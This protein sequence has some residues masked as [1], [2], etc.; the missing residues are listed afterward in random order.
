[1]HPNRNLTRIKKPGF[2]L[3]ALLLLRCLLPLSQAFAQTDEGLHYPLENKYNFPFSTS[4]V[5]SPMLMPPPSNVTQTVVYDPSTN[6]YVFSEKVGTL[7]YRPPSLMSFNQYQNYQRNQAKTDYWRTKSREESGAGPD[8]MKGFRLGNQSI[9]KVFGS[10]A[11]SITPQGSA[12]LIFGYAI[13]TNRN[14][15]IPVNNQRN[16]SFIFKEK[17]MMNVTGAIGD[18]LQVGLNYNTEASFDFENK[19]KLEYSGK[20]DEIIKKIQAGDVSFPVP[21]TLITG[22]QSLFGIYTELQ[23]GRLTVSTILSNQKSQQSSVKVQGGAQQTEFEVDIDN[24]DANRHFF[25]S[26]FFRDNYNAWLKNPQNIES[27][28]RIENI[29]VWVVNRQGNF[30][31]SRN[32]VGIMD[33]AEGYDPNG[34]PNFLANPELIYPTPIKRNQPS[35]NDLNSLYNNLVS[36]PAI[37]NLSSI[38]QVFAGLSRNNYIFYE[39]RDY[40]TIENA[41]PLSEREFTVNRELG[42]ISLNS[43]LRNDEILAVAYVYTYKGEIKKVGELSTEQPSP[44]VLLVKLLKGVIQAPRLPNWD[45]MMKNVYSIGAFQVSSENFVLDVLYRNDKTGVA[46]NVIKETNPNASISEEVDGKILLKVMNLDKLDARKEPYPDGM[47]DFI[48]GVTINTRNGRIFFPEVEPFGSDLRAKIVG[49]TTTLSSDIIKAR[50]RTADKYV[51]EEL[52]DSTQTNAQQVAE[53]N[54]FFLKGRY[55]SSGSSDI[56]LNAMNVPAGSVKVTA[57]GVL[58]T[59]NVDYTVDYALGR[60][61]ILN[62]GLVES[63]TP[64]NVSLENNSAFSI[65]QKTLLGTHLD[66]K[67][68]E[69]FNLGATI[70]RLNERPLTQK[71]NIGEEPIS[72]TIWG[73]NT[74]YRTESQFLTSLI[75]KL[76]FLETK[77]PSSIALDAEFA[78]LIPGQSKAIGENG[79]AYIDDF[80]G[81]QTK[82]E[83]KAFQPWALASAP[84]TDP[85]SRFTFFNSN[86]DGLESGFGRGKLAWYI[87]DPI[88]Y[89]SSSGKPD[90]PDSSLYSHEQRE[91]LMKEL[92]PNRDDDIPGFT[93]RISVLNLNYYPNERGPYNYDPVSNDISLNNPTERWGG[94][95]REIVTSDFESSNIEYIEFWLM[96]PYL[97]REGHDGG[98]LFLQLGEMSEDILRDNRKSAENGLPTSEEKVNVDTTVWGIVPNGTILVTAFNNDPD[99][100]AF[101]DVGFDGLNDFEEEEFFPEFDALSDPAGDN[102]KYFLGSE[103]DNA[104]SSILERYKNINGVENNTPVA[105]G[106]NVNS[107][108]STPDVEDINKDNTLNSTETYYQY[109]VNLRSQAFEVGSNYI[110]DQ[111]TYKSDK[112]DIPAKWYQFRI[113]ISEFESKVGPITDFKSI[114]FMRLVMSG[115]EEPVVLRF[116]TLE[117]VRGEWRRY[118]SDLQKAIPSVTEQ[119]DGTSFEVSSVNIEENGN[120]QPVN[121]ILPEGITRQTDPSQPQVKQLNEQ[122]L[123]V[124][125]GNLQE[126]DGRA[127]YKNTQFDLR[128]YKYLQMFIHAEALPGQES[129]L[130]DDEV[131]AFVRIGSDYQDNYYEYEIPLKVTRHRN[132]GELI[133]A[134]EVWPDSNKLY[135][136]LNKLVGLKVLRDEAIENNPQISSQSVYTIYDGKNRIKIKGNPNLSNI[137]QIMMGVRNP[138]DEYLNIDNDGLPKS[139]EVWFNE[140]RITDFNNDGGWAANGRVQA[141]L[142]DLGIFNVAGATSKPGFG[143]IEQQTTERQQEE[144]NQFDISTNLEMGKFF[145]EKSK[146]SLPLYMGYSTMVQNPEYYPKEP[147]RKL[148]DVLDAAE[149]AE[150]RREIKKISQDLTER[151]S[152]NLTNARWNKQFKKFQVFQPANFSANVLYSQTQASNYSI[153]YN[154]TRKYGAGLNYVYNYRP[155]EVEP[156]KNIKALAKPSYRIIRDFNFNYLPSSFTFGTRF[157]RNYQTMKVRNVYE[158][159]DLVIEPTT[160]KYLHWDREYTF[161]WDLTRALKFSYSATNNAIV[162]EPYYDEY[163]NNYSSADLFESNNQMWKDSV[164]AQILQGGRTLQFYQKMDLSYTLPLNK[165]PLL[166]WTNF[167][168]SYGATYN[169]IHGPILLSEPGVPSRNLGHT[170]KNGNAMDF[171]ATL[172]MKNLYSKVGY[173]K[174]LDRKYSPQ[175]S[176][177][178][179]E[180]RYKTVEFQKITFFE[181]DTPKTIQHKLNTE[182]VVVKVTDSEGNEVNVK[183][184]IVNP[185]K[186]T[187][188]TD[189]DLTGANVLVEGKI[190]KGE[191]PVVFIGENGIR[192]LLGIKNISLNYTRNSST[193]LSGYLPQTNMFGF[194]MANF[195]GAPGWPIVLGWQDEDINQHFSEKNWLTTDSTFSTP[196]LFGITESFNSRTTFEPFNGFRVD[197]SA[198]RS[199][200]RTAEQKYLN[201][202]DTNGFQQTL[203]NKYVGGNYTRSVIT[204]GTAFEGLSP[205]NNWESAAYNQLKENRSVI[206]QR[207]SNRATSGDETYEPNISRPVEPGYGDGYSSTSSEV[208]MYSF[209]SAYTGTDPE[210]IQLEPFSWLMLPNWKVTFD[211]LTKLDLVK[212][213][214]K[215]LTLTHSYQSR[216]SIGQYTTNVD[217]YDDNLAE[218]T[219]ALL[220]RDAQGDFIPQYR[221]NSVSINEQISPLIG[222]D[223]TWHSSLL[224]KFEIKHSRLLTLSLNNQQLSETRNK[225]YVFGAGYIFKNVPLTINTAGGSK[226]IKSD[227]NLRFDLTV[228]DNITILRTINET[229]ADQATTGARKFILGLSADYL[230]SQRVNV[231]FYI[232]WNKNTPFVSTYFPNSE[233][234]FG[235][236]LRLSL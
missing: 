121:Y 161:R 142:A 197:F 98:D 137:R 74:S 229:S 85:N 220:R 123:L 42:Y 154:K 175:G 14:P 196:T 181:K 157:D 185:N 201:S 105:S 60:V 188:E 198:M 8:F 156:F 106:D 57:G 183:T 153:D 95:M 150:E 126:N 190:E 80:E 122:S 94:M 140:L 7:N 107:V 51:F 148:K 182:M 40:I 224:T 16:G 101:Q 160:S 184:V 117:L 207:L 171:Q 54:K 129:S 12:E 26:H 64:I 56:Q 152:I 206:S 110:V 17:I 70:L 205:D 23:F 18:K 199:F 204:I 203:D 233:F 216:Y 120:K 134:D 189:R 180:A 163:G 32:I 61:K 20:E 49:D 35:E 236:S 230:V 22:S 30:E 24:Y 93:S 34:N 179:K 113:P 59:E 21:G 186:V 33:L 38:D 130:Q 13:T 192:L 90:V 221:V 208:L 165:I 52:Y 202:Y 86:R 112:N 72:N 73:L 114:R 71:V 81:A 193:M 124:K 143:S 128:Q 234:S 29:E 100:R 174:T 138:G 97:E 76:P 116:A 222:F 15:S 115:F 178:N 111:V 168:A 84:R 141:K 210:K 170:L 27:Q 31:Q 48:E 147:D 119:N 211:G 191:N 36:N 69:N 55:Q 47:L 149:S 218:Q 66:Y 225:D 133:P 226:T 162:D 19:T 96:D 219:R 79:V 228:R 177:T 209:L 78:Q 214:L 132:G 4:G 158:D 125:F 11:I 2:F 102:F 82:I 103:Y 135:L 131:S 127:V 213:F 164:K 172:N 91:V 145:P 10:E 144:I 6:S 63:G 231:Q 235:F 167:K 173:F 151:S 212:K 217:F 28:V 104:G 3:A 1:M 227:L 5:V 195:Y 155:K 43:P 223:M 136:E 169:W 215:T 159:V 65:Q 77:E 146:V 41:R 118:S 44:N 200:T 109:H 67:F 62:Q 92:F 25:L 108:K 99:S 68:S 9:D 58:L 187:V 45:L 88:F 232:D 75:D 53:K 46:T 37:R 87:I 50:N 139:G 83:L 166:N 89:G 194:D 176:K 39:D